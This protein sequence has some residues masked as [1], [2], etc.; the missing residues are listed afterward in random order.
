MVRGLVAAML[1]AALAG[2]GTGDREYERALVGTWG[3]KDVAQDDVIVETETTLLPGGRVNWRGELRLPVPATFYVPR[4]VNH[5]VKNG[6]LIFYFTASG[7]WSV[8]E[9]FLHTRVESSTLPSLMPVGFST[10][11]QLKEVSTRELVYVTASNGRT[12]VEY[13]KD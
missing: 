2:C 1:L 6:R 9:G 5:E 11:W 8:R 3:S 7:A 10:A 4:G 12:R 13:R